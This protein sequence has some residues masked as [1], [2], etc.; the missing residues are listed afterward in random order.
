MAE[1]Y[2]HFI[3]RSRLTNCLIQQTWICA[4]S[5]TFEA[6]GVLEVVAY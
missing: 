5:V 3:D 4:G 2:H 1:N 6:Q